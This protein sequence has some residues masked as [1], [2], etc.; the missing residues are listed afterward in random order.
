MKISFNV[1][2][3]TCAACSARVEKATSAVPGVASVAV[4]L[5]KNSME[6]QLVADADA[7]ETAA[8][9]ESAVKKA[10]YGASPKGQAGASSGPGATAATSSGVAAGSGVAAEN[11][12]AAAEAEQKSML[13]R[14][15]A[16]LVFTV[17]LFYISMGDM[18][19]WPLPSALTGMEN[20][21]V[22]GLTL[23]VLLVPVV[24]IN[25]KFFRVG[26]RA[27]VNRAPNMDSLIALGSGAATVYGIY[28]LFNM[29]FFMGHSDMAA[30]YHFAM[31]LYFESAAMI[32]TLITLGKY[33]EARAKG[34]TTS[35]LSKL[36]DLS[37]K[38][39]TRV[40]DDVEVQ[41]PVAV[42]AEDGCAHSAYGRIGAGRRRGAGR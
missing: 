24:F 6:V 33:L 37:P 7:A 29:A 9:I 28:A 31:N 13:H 27:L 18:F 34:K 23:F 35:S 14:L 19:G 1:Q 38:M 12:N 26:F 16:S 10:G 17:P 20:M 30:A 41:V 39:A 36:M 25:F 5:L 21:M 11:P 40:E 4:N 32:L 42:V 3:M 8:A 2:G 22:Y 15:I